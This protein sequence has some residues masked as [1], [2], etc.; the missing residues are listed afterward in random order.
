MSC[1]RRICWVPVSRKS[2][3]SKRASAPS[4]RNRFKKLRGVTSSRRLPW[5]ASCEAQ[6]NHA[7][8][9]ATESDM[10]DLKYVTSDTRDGIA[11]ITVNRPDKLNALNAETVGELK[12]ALTRVA[13][14]AAVRVVILTGAGEKSFVAGADI[15]ELA[16]MSP[17]SGIRVSRQG[18]D[19]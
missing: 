4:M 1:C 8:W 18:Q 13:D 14:D 12:I 3:N 11:V 6:E 16:K 5:K 9:R 2:P 7:E 17:L 15:G 10:A 19:T